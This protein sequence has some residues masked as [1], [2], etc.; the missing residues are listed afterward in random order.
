MNR[1]LLEAMKFLESIELVHTDL[2]LENILF[3][4]SSSTSTRI[5]F[6]GKDRDVTLPSNTRIK[7]LFV[8]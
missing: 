5:S 2:K 3:M 7:G 1:Q 4:Y 8:I 6:R